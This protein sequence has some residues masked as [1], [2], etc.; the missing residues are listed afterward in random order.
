MVSLL[1]PFPKSLPRFAWKAAPVLLW[2]LLTLTGCGTDAPAFPAPTQS[3][4]VVKVEEIESNHDE[5]VEVAFVPPR[6]DAAC[7]DC[8]MD[9]QRLIDTG[10]PEEVLEVES[11]GE[12]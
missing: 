7:I 8:H 1:P 2:G 10:E 6:A 4:P 9:K 12:G 5:P 11:T 3:N